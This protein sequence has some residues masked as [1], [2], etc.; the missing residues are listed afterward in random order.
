M[1][2][3]KAVLDTNVLI[4]ALLFDGECAKLVPLWKKGKFVCLLSKPILEE[5]VRALAYPKFQLTDKEIKAL[6]EEDVLPFVETVS[7]KKIS[8]P[9]LKDRDDEK[10]LAASVAGEADYLVTGDRGLLELGKC[11]DVII[12]APSKFLPVIR[13]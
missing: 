8:V 3:P 9:R 6:I 5:Y 10:F 13:D 1:K 12:M 11:R 7:E 4:S 2:P